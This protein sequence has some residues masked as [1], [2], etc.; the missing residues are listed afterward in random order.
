M[1]TDHFS[2]LSDP[3]SPLPSRFRA[4]FTLK[5]VLGPDASLGIGQALL[6]SLD[7]VLLCHEMAYVLGQLGNPIVIPIL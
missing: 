1:T 5:S 7:N 4:L 2:I 6:N 3:Q